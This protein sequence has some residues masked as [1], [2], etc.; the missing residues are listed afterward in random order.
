MPDS[1]LRVL[2]VSAHDHASAAARALA[3]AGH[4]VCWVA[5]EATPLPGIEAFSLPLRLPPGKRRDALLAA[6][7]ARAALLRRAQVA[8]VEAAPATLAV[9]AAL[10]ALRLP[11]VMT[12]D[13]STVAGFE[14]PEPRPALLELQRGAL[15]TAAH[16]ARRVLV[17]SGRDAEVVAR[18][19]AEPRLEIHAPGISLEA[20]PL[21]SREEAREA[22]GLVQAS[23]FVA[24][25]ADLEPELRLDLLALAHRRLAGVGLLIA[26]EG[27]QLALIGPMEMATRPSSPVLHLGPR[28]PA[29]TVAATLA[30]DVTLS[31][32]PTGLDP[33]ALESAALGRRQVVLAE[34]TAAA[35]AALYPGEDAVRRADPHPEALLSALSD[36]LEA[37]ARGPL[38]AVAAARDRL[39]A[40][41][42]GERLAELLARC[43]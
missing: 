7:A 42:S 36:A 9:P 8:L 27:P 13:A 22:M 14:A 41:R 34:E 5:P 30:A 24:L 25:V 32:S 43:V 15:T 12:M 33:R 39:D 37:E 21:A 17:P 26:G 6:V 20:L 19:L 28:T 11:V 40:T 1:T 31:L 16:L 35:V 4:R 23:R 18:A 29:T 3:G 2:V 10:A 38:G